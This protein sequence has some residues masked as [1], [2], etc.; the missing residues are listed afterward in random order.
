MI[1]KNEIL[2]VCGLTG[3]VSLSL[4]FSE[5]TFA[6]LSMLYLGLIEKTCIVNTPESEEF[7]NIDAGFKCYMTYMFSSIAILGSGK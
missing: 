3:M 7:K 4:V 1:Y 2:K 6:K 5:N